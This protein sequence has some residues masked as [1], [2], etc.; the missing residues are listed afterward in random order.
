MLS[1][2]AYPRVLVTFAGADSFRDPLEIDAEQFVAVKGLRAKGKRVTTLNV[3][4]VEELPPLRPPE[5]PLT[6]ESP[7]PDA[8]N[9]PE[10]ETDEPNVIDEG[11]SIQLDLFSME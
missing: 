1:Q 11:N 6:D 3:A 8:D 4:T 2:E 5:P 10:A 7:I 9:G